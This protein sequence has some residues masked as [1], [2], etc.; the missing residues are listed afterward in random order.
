MSWTGTIT[1][2]I[3]HQVTWEFIEEDGKQTARHAF[4][5][6]EADL[7]EV[8][9][10]AFLH[11]YDRETWMTTGNDG[12]VDIIKQVWDGDIVVSPEESSVNLE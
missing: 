2:E 5:G 1:V 4:E 10:L 6:C 3:T 12:K 7:Q 11:G 9:S 8:M